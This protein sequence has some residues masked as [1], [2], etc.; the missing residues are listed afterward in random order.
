MDRRT[1][2]RRRS[3]SSREGN[4]GFTLVE[5]LFTL[6][7]IG[8]LTIVSVPQ[9][10][11]SL[12]KSRG[13]AAARYVASRMAL[14]RA[15]AVSRSANVALRFTAGA[16]GTFVA[17]FMDGN[18]NGVRMADIEADID[19]VVSADVLL[20]DLFPG[21]QVTLEPE[22]AVAAGP[23]RL[24]SFTAM[25]TATSGSVYLRGPDGTQWAVRV[26]GTTGRTRVL[27]YSP[28]DGGWT[29]AF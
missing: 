10:L 20:S 12:S 18:A 28:A 8:V 9:V 16:G 29:Q 2:R 11:S 26:L 1:Y 3:H 21:V 14:A 19:P 27:R 4:G 6:G 17:V 7:L 24:F 25:G 13:V 15:Q 23:S 5:V 22:G